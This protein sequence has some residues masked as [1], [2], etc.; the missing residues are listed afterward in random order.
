MLNKIKIGPKLI[1]GFLVV[2]VT[3]LAVGVL[4]INNMGKINNMLNTLYEK[5]LV[6]I[7]TVKEANINLIYIGRA[8]RNM[9]LSDSQEERDTH[10]RAIE[11]YDASIRAELDVASKTV[12]TDEG[13]VLSQKTY[14][15]YN[16][17][18]KSVQGFITLITKQELLKINQTVMDGLAETRQKADDIDKTMTDFAVMKDKLGKQMYDESD[19]IYNHMRNVLILCIIIA[20]I[21]GILI[22]LF[23][24]R[25]ISVPLAKT[26]KM[27][28]ELGKGHLGMRLKMDSQDEIGI[29]AQTM[30]KF[31]DDLQTNVVGTMQKIADGDTSMEVSM[32]DN[33]D[34][35]TPALKKTIDSLRGL[36]TEAEMLRKAAIEGKLTVRG[37]SGNFKGGY[38]EIV[39]GFNDTLDAVIV[40]LNMAAKYV[41]DISKGITPAVITE[42]YNGD[43]NLIKNNLNAVVKMMSQ[44]LLETDIIIKSAADGELDKRANAALFVGNWNKLVTGINDTITNIVNPLMMTADYVEKVSKGVIPPEITTVYKGQYNIIKENLNAVVKMMSLLLQETDVIIK[45]AADGELNKRAN[46]AHFAG[47]WNK[48]VCGVNDTITNIVNPL[49]MTADY[50]DKVSKGVIPP[51]ITTVYNGQYNIIKNNLNAVVKMMSELLR[52]TDTLVNAALTGNLST[53]A[54]TTTFVGGWNQLVTGINKTL[55]AVIEPV[56][57]AAS[58]LEKVAARDM[59]ARVKGDYKGD[60]AKI[61]IALNTAVNNL[62]EALSQVAQ[63]TEQVS[64]AGQQI[65]SGSQSLAQGANEQASSLEEVSSSLEEMASMTK[66]NAENASQAKELAGI[67]N[68]NTAQGKQDMTRMSDSINKIKVSSDQTAKIVKTIDEIAM[69]TNL[70]AL[71]AAVEAARA[72]EAGRGFA[73]VAEE[74]RNLAQRSAQAAKNTADMIADSVRN[75]DEGVKI[76]VDVS[77]SFESIATSNAKVNDLISEIAAASQEQSQGIDQ[78]N[79]AVAQ[80]DKVTQQNA[81]NSEESASAAE[82]LS[83]QAEELQ[84]MVGQFTLTNAGQKTA[85]KTVVHH[86]KKVTRR[87]EKKTDPKIAIGLD[88]DDVLAEF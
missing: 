80:M 9:I 27:I 2:A 39:L 72:G 69:Q 77:K 68:N 45:A 54:N 20:T 64:A 87:I 86:D 19:M 81:A 78:V 84:N 17:Y 33:Q 79:T 36:I 29:M 4:S 35:I 51:E 22:G 16:N 75:A 10:A 23:L 65:S 49:M 70:L 5:H 52:E 41:D 11:K 61:K 37:N 76:A 63:G 7:S 6:G 18:Y 13:K 57:E 12:M 53:R 59:T 47:G 43:F 56:N 32:K 34:E 40:P 31:A 3:T 26:V 83:S 55:D 62:D 85:V 74:V 58:I 82:E 24:S 42:N 71:N 44:L 66:Q 1:G 14:D 21:A 50:V 30:D 48:L 73:V 28:Q 46:T 8:M 60:H 88:G 67:A 25:S 38:K 15:D